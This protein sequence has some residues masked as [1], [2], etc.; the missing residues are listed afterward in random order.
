MHMPLCL[1]LCFLVFKNF[2]FTWKYTWFVLSNLLK[3]LVCAMMYVVSGACAP[4]HMWRSE[5]YIVKLVIF[6]LYGLQPVKAGSQTLWRALFCPLYSPPCSIYSSLTAWGP[7]YLSSFC[8][9][10]FLLPGQSCLK[11]NFGLNSWAVLC[12]SFCNA[13]IAYVCRHSGVFFFKRRS[14]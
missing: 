8:S 7:L 9:S 10:F 13:E 3:L 4:V 1:V 2:N 6:P 11:F 5:D 12:L 14:H